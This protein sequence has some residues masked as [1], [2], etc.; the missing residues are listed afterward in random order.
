VL[1]IDPPKQSGTIAV[2]AVIVAL[3]GVFK[4]GRPGSAIEGRIDAVT[5]KDVI[6]IPAPALAQTLLYRLNSDRTSAVPVKVEYGRLGADEAEIRGG[7]NPGDR[8]I[9]SS[10]AVYEASGKITITGP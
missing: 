7:L 9:V 8:V 1:R 3:D 10:T 4:D 5:L 2:T 6:H